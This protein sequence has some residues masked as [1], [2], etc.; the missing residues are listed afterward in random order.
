M[1]IV[2]QGDLK[3]F[4][5]EQGADMKFVGGQ[6]TMDRGWENA[7]IFSLFTRSWVGNDLFDDPN[8]KLE[9]D[10]EETAS[11]PITLSNISDVEK[12]AESAL[13]WMLDTGVADEIIVEATNPSGNIRQIKIIIRPPGSDARELLITKN[14]ENWILQASDPAHLR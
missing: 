14:G 9:S 6:P 13:A 7:V 11:R 4:L 5:T 8:Q 1:I 10:F 2:F 3:V 12:S